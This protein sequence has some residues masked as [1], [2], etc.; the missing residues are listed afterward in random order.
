MMLKEKLSVAS[1]RLAVGIIAG[2]SLLSGA[3]Q[4]QDQKP[5]A[6]LSTE[7]AAP[8]QK[9]FVTGSNIRRISVETASPVQV[10][11]KEEITRG[12]ATSLTEAL[13]NISSNVGGIDENR[14]GGFSAGASGLN[15]R[16]IGSQATLLLI[17]GR[18]LA[19]YA[20]PEFQTTF[21][22]LNS[23]PVGAVERIEILKDGA[24][25]IYGS[26]AMAGV[27]NI[28]LRNSFEGLEASG[29]YGQSSRSDGEQTRATLSFGKGNLATD[30]FN[31]YATL[32][33][34]SRDPMLI[35]KRDDYLSTTD[36]T[37]YGYKDARNL[38]TYPGNIYWTDPRTNTFV[39]RSLGACPEGR[40]VPASVQFGAGAQGT[41]CVFD[42]FKDSNY[43]SAPETDRIGLTSR[44]TWQ[45][46]AT[47]TVWSEIMFNQNKSS[48]SGFPH[49][50]AGQNGQTTPA[51]PITH[52]QYP[53]DLIDPVTGRTL[54]GGNGTVRVRA[55]L[56][57]FPGQGQD[58][59]TNFGRYL[60]GA[61]GVV[62]S[63]DWETALLSTSST[64]KSKRTAGILNTPFL[65]AYKSGTYLFGGPNS[66]ALYDSLLTDSASSFKSGVTQLDGK[67]TGE[68]FNLP[69]GA[70]GIAVGAEVRRESL[71]T[72]PDA[73]AV[74]G[75][76]FH[77]ATA[78]PGFSNSRRVTSLF[79]EAT[80][81]VLKS[82]EAQLAVRYDRYSDY[83]NSTTPKVGLKWTAMPTLV[84][85]GTYAEGFRAP[86]LVENSTDV[87][88]AFISFRDP[89]RCNARYTVGCNDS[90]PYSSG[91]NPNLGPE[92]AKSFTL[93]TVWEPA[94]WLYTSVDLWR[95]Q[96]INEI[97]TYDLSKVLANPARYA[98]DPAVKIVRDPLTA[99]DAALG[100][101]AGEVTSITS[102]LTNVSLTDI[103]GV[104]LEVRGKFN[105][106]EYGIFEP[107][108]TGQYT[109]SY[110]NA[111]SPTDS[112]IEYAG[113]RGTPRAQA[114]LGLGWRKA[115]W[116]AS[117]D[118]AMVG[119]MSSKDDYTEE[120]VL[121]TEG[122]P[123][124]CNGVPSF[125]TV[126]LGASYRGLFGLKDMR[127]S[128][129]VQNAFD[130]MPPFV[131]YSGLGYYRP[132]H[133]P[134][135]RY[136]QLTVDYRFK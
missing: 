106:G 95:I 13:R 2:T 136:F 57:D 71:E 109:H 58:N 112:L 124:L 22:D 73:L 97:G 66:P 6:P 23:V 28:I 24:S 49:F 3:A 125:T 45:P 37:K 19:P 80:V 59:T 38:Y 128:V 104:D 123:G 5:A 88:Q 87:R 4:A 115:A 102:L 30:R 76:I 1:V 53:K 41:V 15:L 52:P 27:V 75:E 20:Q 96:R 100:A 77:T 69:A 32:D 61:K 92:T 126:N 18:R 12:G 54:V 67:L 127:V 11:T 31:A 120:C 39:A 43:N 119:H 99:A 98:G 47:T 133:N 29:S 63:Y 25:A 108:F 68:L 21:V 110:K 74:A 81:P 105:M 55:S 101:T 116:T 10:I 42:D 107:R 132:L 56:T 84:F 86:T 40:T 60:V 85:R 130:R 93:G 64:V 129:A 78:P 114:N 91:A 35:K 103:R 33:V 117:A 70:V 135:G 36:W 90:S 7:K 34:R 48:I 134:M 44:L 131:P 79:T 26:E 82:V 89:E 118:I 51:L 94:S 16:G 46:T 50:V 8:V 62:G 17:N 121:A 72:N 122:Y 111:P 14:V 9:V 113:T 65:N 83:G